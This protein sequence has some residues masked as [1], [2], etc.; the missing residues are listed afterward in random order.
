MRQSTGDLFLDLFIDIIIELGPIILFNKEKKAF[1][2][3][4][5]GATKDVR[6]TTTLCAKS[7]KA[8]V[9]ISFKH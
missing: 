3:V 8:M 7:S 5:G 1:P 6:T 4:S 9:Q 2:R